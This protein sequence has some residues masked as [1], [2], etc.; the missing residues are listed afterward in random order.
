MTGVPQRQ[1]WRSA[2]STCSRASTTWSF[3]HQSTGA[4]ARYA[5][6]AL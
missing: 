1:Q 2:P 5:S 3:G 6:P 4:I